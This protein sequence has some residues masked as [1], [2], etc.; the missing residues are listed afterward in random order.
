[1]DYGSL[2]NWNF[3]DNPST[4]T[5]DSVGGFSDS[6]GNVPSAMDFSTVANGFKLAGL[7]MDLYGTYMQGQETAAADNYN[8]D[9]V[10]LQSSF[11]IG[12]LDRYETIL[13]GQQEALY[14]KAGVAMSGSVLDNMLDS[15]SQIELDKQ[16]TTFNSKSKSDMLRYQGDMAKYQAKMKMGQELLSTGASFAMG[17]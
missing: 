2:D 9:L 11:Q 6:S 1:M 5:S 16:I 14:A 3:L 7:G 10:G 8:A 4:V 13:G 17:G 12:K 15:A